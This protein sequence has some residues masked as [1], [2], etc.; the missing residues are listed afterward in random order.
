MQNLVRPTLVAMATT[1]A[2]GTESNRLPAC[3][4]LLPPGGIVIVRSF[5]RDTG[6][7][8]SK[9]TSPVFIKFG[10]HVQHLC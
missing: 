9:I 3:V 4:L 2:I 10:T 5:V 6:S 7:D 1:F 8:L